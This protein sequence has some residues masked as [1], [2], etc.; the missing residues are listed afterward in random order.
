MKWKWMI[1]AAL[2]VACMVLTP[3]GAV[4]KQNPPSA[5][6]DYAGVMD[7]IPFGPYCLEGPGDTAAS[8]GI[9]QMD[10]VFASVPGWRAPHE[11]KVR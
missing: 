4:A 8:L 3:T 1:I 10:P 2:L 6:Q 5:K 11:A 7:E 9:A